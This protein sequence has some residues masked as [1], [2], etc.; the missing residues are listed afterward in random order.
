MDSMEYSDDS[1]DKETVESSIDDEVLDTDGEEDTL[2]DCSDD[3]QIFQ[4]NPR[5][6]H[7]EH[8]IE[9]DKILKN[10]KLVEVLTID[11]FMDC[12]ISYLKQLYK[13]PNLKSL[14]L[15]HGFNGDWE[16][17]FSNVKNFKLTHLYIKD[18]I[19]YF[20]I[21]ACTKAFP[22][23]ISFD[24][25]KIV[26]HSFSMFQ[27]MSRNW[28]SLKSLRLKLKEDE[29]AGCY[30]DQ[31]AKDCVFPNLTN[32]MFKV[33]ECNSMKEV[34]T[35]FKA[36]KLEVLGF[37]FYDGNIQNIAVLNQNCPNIKLVNLYGNNYATKA[38]MKEMFPNAQC[39]KY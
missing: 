35:Y 15:A 17:S 11:S 8:A 3:S 32:M 19:M 23:M 39:N 6:L 37:L 20:D 14:T 31:G 34:F 22:N 25:G 1:F 36:P 24:C 13:L 29:Y 10:H 2:E 30:D 21:I 26:D 33:V 12:G 5:E 9:F 7:L 18:I 27:A 16:A 4:E 38:L 28:P